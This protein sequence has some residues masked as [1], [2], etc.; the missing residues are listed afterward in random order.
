[1]AI[2]AALVAQPKLLILD[3]PLASLDLGTQREIV[4][5]LRVLHR[6][7]GVTILVAVHDLNPFLSVLDSAIYL[8]GGRPQ[9]DT[10]EDVVE[11]TLLSELY[12]T[13]IEVAHTARGG[14]YV[15]G[16]V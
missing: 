4:K 6:D 16:I 5:L 7:L 8:V 13:R 1:M 14:L 12:R 11:E 10:I 15:R 9:Y 3:E 2:A